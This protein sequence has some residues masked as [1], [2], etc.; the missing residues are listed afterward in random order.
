MILDKLS[1]LS[2][3]FINL[4][5]SIF[6]S[7][8]LTYESSIWVS[9]FNKLFSS[10]GSETSIPFNLSTSS[11]SIFIYNSIPI[12]SINPDCSAPKIS[13]APLIDKSLIA[14]PKPL[15]NDANS[16]IAESLFVATSLNT[17]C[18]SYIKYAYAILLVLPTLPLIWYNWLSPN[19]SESNI[20]SVFAFGIS[21][22]VS[23][24]VVQSKISNSPLINLYIISSISDLFILPCA[25]PILTFGIN[26]SI[27]ETL[28]SKLSIWLH[29]M[30]TWPP[31][32]NSFSTA[33]F[34][35]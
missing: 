24:I 20:I 11:L 31:L 5:I 12:V 27:L 16:F 29:N 2:I 3:S 30:K 9:T 14:I 26:F 35:I 15:P 22:P 32:D 1:K 19:L 23:I 8:S 25:I 18:F 21:I 13:P 7:S 34:S 28:L 17:L 6:K 33:S 4:W 10:D